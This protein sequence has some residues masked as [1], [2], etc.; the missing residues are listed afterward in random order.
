MREVYLGLIAKRMTNAC[1]K[2]KKKKKI[3]KK[4][5]KEG[6][7]RLKVDVRLTCPHGEHNEQ[8]YKNGILEQPQVSLFHQL[9]PTRTQFRNR[10]RFRLRLAR[11]PRHSRQ[12]RRQ[13][14]TMLVIRKLLHASAVVNVFAQHGPQQSVLYV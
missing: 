6:N 5:K 14:P 12:K 9:I 1:L 7:A 10:E 8:K 11:L 13:I 3:K 4:K 2:K